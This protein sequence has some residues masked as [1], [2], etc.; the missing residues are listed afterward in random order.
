MDAITNEHFTIANFTDTS[1]NPRPPRSTARASSSQPGLVGYFWLW[2]GVANQ[3][4]YWSAYGLATRPSGNSTSTSRC[5]PPR[6]QHRGRRRHPAVRLQGTCPQPSILKK[7]DPPA[8]SPSCFAELVA[9]HVNSTKSPLWSPA[10]RAGLPSSTRPAPFISR[11][12]ARSGSTRRVEAPRTRDHRPRRRLCSRT[13][14]ATRPSHSPRR[15]RRERPEMIAC[16]VECRR[17]GIDGFFVHPTSPG[18]NS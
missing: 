14:P 1:G 2:P 9:E 12:A 18:S 7:T 5:D 3:E 4:Q 10:P 8:R 15:I 16:E 6:R 17:D 11:Q 13:T